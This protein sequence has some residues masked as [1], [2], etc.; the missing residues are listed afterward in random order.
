MPN[1]LLKE[2]IVDSDKIN[3]LSAQAEVFFYRLLVVSDDFGCMDARTSILRAR[4]FPL[5]DNITGD[6]INKWIAEL[7][8]QKLLISYSCEGQPYIQIL[9]WEQRVRSK[10]KYPQPTVD[11]LEGTCQALDSNLQT[12]DGLGKGKGKGRGASTNIRFDADNGSF[13]GIEENQIEVW[14]KAFPAVDLNLEIAKAS[15]WLIANP[16][17]TKSNYNRFL[18][19]WFTR[20]QDS[21]GTRVKDE[22]SSGKP[23]WA[24][25]LANAR[26]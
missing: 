15:A 23:D 18:T 5:R 9:K 6:H 16:K 11:Q 13:D 3:S 25:G 19:S 14:K 22:K 10:G 8:E 7:L 1:R 24:K 2:G 26:T 12:Y 17:Q 21:G 4:C 20:C